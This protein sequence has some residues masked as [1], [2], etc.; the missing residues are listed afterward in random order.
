MDDFVAKQKI[1][2]LEDKFRL[3]LQNIDIPS[4]TEHLSINDDIVSN[5]K[6]KEVNNPKINEKVY[7]NPFKLFDDEVNKEN[8]EAVSKEENINLINKRLQ[9]QVNHSDGGS[10]HDLVAKNK[11]IRNLVSYHFLL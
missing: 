2:L 5:N 4:E 7:I 11:S 9:K 6:R 10:V 1:L 8:V 3:G